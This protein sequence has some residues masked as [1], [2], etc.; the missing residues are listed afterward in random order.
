MNV[1][2]PARIGRSLAGGAVVLALSNQ[3]ASQAFEQRDFSEPHSYR[4]P[5]RPVECSFEVHS[6]SSGR[7]DARWCWLALPPRS[8]TLTTAEIHRSGDINAAFSREARASD[9]I[10]TSGGYFGYDAKNRY[11]PLG[12][13]VSQGRVV[14]AVKPWRTGGVVSQRSGSIDVTPLGGFAGP[15]EVDEALES[16]PLLFGN[17]RV[18]APFRGGAANRAAIGVAADGTVIIAGV[19]APADRAAT[20]EQ[21]AEFMNTAARRRGMTIKSVVALDGGPSAHLFIPSLELHFG[22]DGERYVPNLLHFAAR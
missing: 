20:L 6:F 8:V 7:S 5:C 21:F 4:L 22:F 2:S 19:F 14:R 9:L 13:L 17:G 11:M 16:M 12:L 3:P 18:M 1:A 10:V 15:P